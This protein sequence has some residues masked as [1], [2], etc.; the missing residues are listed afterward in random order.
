MKKKTEIYSSNDMKAFR[1]LPQKN[2]IA[3]EKSQFQKC[4]ILILL[5]NNILHFNEVKKLILFP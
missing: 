5:K 1:V 4:F 3:F 2:R